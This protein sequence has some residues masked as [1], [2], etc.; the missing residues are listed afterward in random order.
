MIGRQLGTGMY[1]ILPWICRG[2]ARTL[3]PPR[4]FHKKDTILYLPH[5]TLHNV[6]FVFCILVYYVHEHPPS[7]QKKENV[8]DGG[9][10]GIDIIE[11]GLYSI[12][13]NLGSYYIASKWDIFLK[14]KKKHEVLFDLWDSL[15]YVVLVSY[16]DQLPQA[17]EVSVC[18]WELGIEPRETLGNRR[19][20]SPLI[21][22]HEAYSRAK[23]DGSLTFPNLRYDC[24]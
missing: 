3:I 1:C 17:S 12:F 4:G 9:T 24:G 11:F 20:Q 22:P 6:V 16:G 8:S 23:A 21:S 7:I 14:K 10:L 18:S 19:N 15:T 2:P 5:L 13:P